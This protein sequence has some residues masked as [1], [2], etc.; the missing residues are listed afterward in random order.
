MQDFARHGGIGFNKWQQL[1][2]R[3]SHRI[4]VPMQAASSGC[5]L[6][7]SKCRS[8]EQELKVNQMAS[9]V[10]IVCEYIFVFFLFVVV[11]EKIRKP[12]GAYKLVSEQNGT[13]ECGENGKFAVIAHGWRE[14]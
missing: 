5:T 4:A 10:F 9:V 11:A 12:D 3:P 8:I 14:R 7:P 13:L 6:V 1:C 2:Y